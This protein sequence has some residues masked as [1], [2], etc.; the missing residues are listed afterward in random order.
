MANAG[1]NSDVEIKL[2]QERSVGECPGIFVAGKVLKTWST[3]TNVVLAIA[4]RA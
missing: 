3:C 4:Y 1:A 2:T